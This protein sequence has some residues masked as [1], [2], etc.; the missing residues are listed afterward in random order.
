MISGPKVEYVGVCMLTVA[1]LIALQVLDG[2][3]MYYVTS[4]VMGVFRSTMYTIPFMLAN[5][6]CQ[7]EVSLHIMC[8]TCFLSK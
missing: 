8:F 5:D 6:I 3:S 4:C 1:M 2:I 7:E